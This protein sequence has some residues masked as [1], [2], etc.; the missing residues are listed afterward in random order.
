M[1]KSAH[2]SVLNSLLFVRDSG[3]REIPHIDGNLAVW[4]TASCIAVS[5]LPDSDGATDVKIGLSQEIGASGD[6]I[7]DLR[8]KTPSGAIIVETVTGQR[9]L[10]MDVPNRDTRVRIWTNGH[11]D[12]DQVT[13]GL[14]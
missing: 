4:S 6:A 14:D 5:C 10:E 7:A 8:L 11:R 9:I 13:I 3:V 12:T 2:V 1:I